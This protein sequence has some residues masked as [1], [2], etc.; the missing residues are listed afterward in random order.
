[1]M[2]FK[3]TPGKW[4]FSSQYD[5]I[6][7]SKP[8]ILEGSKNVCDI[9]DHPNFD[10]TGAT[11]RANARLIAEAPE[12]LQIAI[13]RLEDMNGLFYQNR[14]NENGIKERQRI[15]ELIDKILDYN[16]TNS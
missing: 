13:D 3:G 15:K 7:A 16:E 2:K 4:R 6:T 11:K 1:M 9:S 5:A 14:L 8:G 10:Y 12:L